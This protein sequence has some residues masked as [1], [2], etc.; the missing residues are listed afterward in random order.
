MDIFSAITLLG[1]LAMFLYGMRLMSST[2]KD[3]AS[4]TLKS[5]M[6]KVTNNVFK[7]FLLGVVVTAI[8]QSSTA[9]IIIT[10]GL[11][12][13]G[14]LTL[15]Q[16]LGIIVG[17]NV[18]TTVTGQIIRLLDLNSSSTAWI[19]FFKPSTLA[20]LALIAGIILIMFC[21]FRKSDVIGQ[22]LMGFGILFSG[23]MT[24]TNA[25]TVLTD[26]GVFDQVF[27]K[28]SDSPFVAY[29]A[30]AGVAFILQSSSAAVGILQAF[31]ASGLLY[32]RGVFIAIVGIYLGD[33]L[34]TWM[35]IALG[36]KAEARK[37]AFVNVLFNLGKTVLV[38]LIVN[39]LHGMG[40]IDGLWNS[41]MT[42]GTIA[43]TNT[44]FNIIC[45]ILLI[46]LLTLFEKTANK[47]VRPD[48][49]TASH[50]E[51]K[52]VAL[53]PQ[54]FPT[55]A[56][57]FNSAYDAL[58]TMFDAAR[59]NIRR[60]FD[61]LKTFDASV[62]DTINSEEDE[63]DN[64]ADRIANY[65]VLLSQHISSDYQVQIMHEYYRLLSEFER[66]G[67][68]AVNISESAEALNKGDIH[69]SE[70]ARKEVDVLEKITE[71][72][73]DY[74]RRAFEKRDVDAAKHI[75]PLEQ[76]VDEMINSI[77]EK[78]LD[79]LSRGECSVDAD[80]I[81]LNLLSDIERI[82]DV[83]SN[84]GLAIIARVNPEIVAQQHLYTTH[85]HEGVDETFNRRF[86]EAEEKYFSLLEQAEK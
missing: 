19:Q 9:T 54:F 13:A 14:V 20:P 44:I 16:S 84:I 57:A 41:S 72:I 38:L 76:V 8:I 64:F 70:F 71:D 86:N 53:N 55:P 30:G 28:I 48:K 81:F 83:C 77:R 1:G 43:N 15:R 21:T 11:V 31:S 59:E 27:A 51:E 32:F 17:A 47:I 60:A 82:S 46:P 85:L 75:E 40:L 50:Y 74:S 26:T 18:G 6:E 56:I 35:V 37:V 58:L 2:L 24:M 73:L 33:C 67:D 80:N 63:I 23:L 4:G 49:T 29:G 3:N 39:L 7:A 25:V 45:S 62:I 36:G 12:A 68:H 34:T 42:S 10:S 52:L 78:H 22:I 79:R 66:L 5:I 69:F 65:L 61:L